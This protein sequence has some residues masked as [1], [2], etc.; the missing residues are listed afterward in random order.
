M[1]ELPMVRAYCPKPP[2]PFLSCRH[3][4]WV[5][6]SKASK[7]IN[8]LQADGSFAPLTE[9]YDPPIGEID[10]P[11]CSID[12]AEETRGELTRE[13]IGQLMGMS[14]YGVELMEERVLVKLRKVFKR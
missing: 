2:C 13:E 4:L 11:T 10:H 5:N 3:H 9:D 8:V 6:T 12:V 14:G 7:K 1:R